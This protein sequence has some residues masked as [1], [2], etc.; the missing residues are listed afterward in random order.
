VRRRSTQIAAVVLTLVFV[1][2]C[3]KSSDK[4]VEAGASPTTKGDATTTSAPAAPVY[5][6][7]GVPI[8]NLGLAQHPAVVVKIDNSPDARPQSG[9]NEA[10]V[11]YELLVE[12]ITRYA[13]VY[14]SQGAD[15]VG[16][17]R[18]ARSSDVELLANVG[19]P[20][21]AWSGANPGVNNEVRTAVDNGFLVNAGQDAFP[22]EY[23]RDNSRKAPHNLYTSV[24]GL[25]AVGAPAGAGAPPPLFRY[26]DPFQPYAGGSLPAPG[27]VVDFGGGVRAEYVWDAERAGWDRFQ[28]D[29]SHSRPNSATVDANGV[30]VAPQN[31]VIL[32]LEYGQSP[33]DARSPMALSSGE[34]DA[35]VLTDG[36]AIVGRWRR[37]NALSGWELVDQGGLPILLSPGRTWVALPEAGSLATPLD[38]AGAAELLAFRH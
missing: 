20:L 21:I 33:S 29:Q 14:H 17:V 24:D 11:V 10:D 31:V 35:V 27:Y 28:I 30:Q 37:P 1:A 4:P 9:I 19:S 23:H 12:G 8:D 36:K 2:A 5:P 15:P 3:G 13:L 6:L 25:L 16:P 32:F 26:R 18:S 34:G 7:T 38:D 22:G